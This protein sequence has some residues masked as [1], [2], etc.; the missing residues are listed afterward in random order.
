MARLFT[1]ISL[2][3]L[4]PAVI[5]A[6]GD[7][8][9][10]DDADSASEATEEDTDD[11]SDAE[12][13]EGD[14]ADLIGRWDSVNLVSLTIRDDET[15]LLTQPGAELQGTYT[16]TATEIRLVVEDEP[17]CT[18]EAVYAWTIQEEV[19]T[20]DVVDNSACELL[21]DFIADGEPLTLVTS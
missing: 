19:L 3:I 10:D 13:A 14:P 17:D 9:D 12:T 21:L 8:D 6:C 4:L 5:S 18:Q 20:L 16:A 15:W 2:A 1:L 7:D 11:S